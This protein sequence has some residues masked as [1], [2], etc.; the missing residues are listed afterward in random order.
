MFIDR[1]TELAN[2]EAHHR[3]GR[4]ELFVLYGRRRVG[5]TE[6]LRYFC[7]GKPHIFFI[8]TLSSDADQLAAF[9]QLIHKELAV[10]EL[11][12]ED[13]AGTPAHVLLRPDDQ[14]SAHSRRI[15]AG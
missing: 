8:A 2:L 14:D 15:G 7:A 13:V 12:G 11:A 9:S 3:S 4:S 5:K 10:E 6:L 1:T